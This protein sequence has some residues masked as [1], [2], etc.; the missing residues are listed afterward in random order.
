MI[1]ML[2]KLSLK[3]EVQMSKKQRVETPCSKIS[4]FGFRIFV[5]SALILSASYSAYCA[6][7]ILKNAR[8][9]SY[10][11][12]T[13]IVL[14]SKEAITYTIEKTGSGEIHIRLHNITPVNKFSQIRHFL[15]F[16]IYPHVT[17]NDRIVK[18]VKLKPAY[19]SIDA[20]FKLNTRNASYNIFYLKNPDRL[21]LDFIKVSDKQKIKVIVIDPGHGGHDSGAV[22]RHKRGLI[23]SYKIKEKDIN[24]DIAKQVKKYLRSTDT[25]VILTRERDKFI[26]LKHRVELAKKYKADIFVSIHANA[27]WDKK[28]MGI[29]TYYPDK[30]RNKSGSLKKESIKLAESIHESLI[31]HMGSKDRG[32]KDT[33]FYVLRK[34]YM[35]AVLVEVG[36]I[37][38]YYDA[39]L[40]KKS[41][42]RKKVAQIIAQGILEY[43]NEVEKQKGE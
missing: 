15:F 1:K 23:F 43:K 13:R 39:K 25:R 21:V 20:V 33:M 16:P 38:N 19:H 26:S 12:K 41:S 5:F 10:P 4:I 30:A 3:H 14:D 35:P 34:A 22:G 6:P 36:F 42:Y 17:I 32:V 31:R 2:K 37:S 9:H 18:K 8:Y 11:T 24:L 40:L 27:A 28:M 29:E 7:N